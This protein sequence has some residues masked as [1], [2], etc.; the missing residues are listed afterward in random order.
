MCWWPVQACWIERAIPG[1]IN[2]D[3]LE[4]RLIV[5][6]N[7]LIKD[8]QRQPQSCYN[9]NDIQRISHLN[10]WFVIKQLLNSRSDLRRWVLVSETERVD[11]SYQ[12]TMFPVRLYETS[13]R[14]TVWWH[15]PHATLCE[16]KY[17]IIRLALRICFHPCSTILKGCLGWGVY[18]AFYLWCEILVK[19]CPAYTEILQVTAAWQSKYGKTFI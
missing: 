1:T 10:F 13:Q 18:R 5:F 4:V 14:K 6:N 2:P 11:I 17:K 3:K 12:M 16:P 9:N 7:N 19:F 15:C 8:I